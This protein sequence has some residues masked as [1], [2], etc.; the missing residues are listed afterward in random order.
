M[1]QLDQLLKDIT[2][3]QIKGN[4]ERRITGICFDS[5]KATPGSL[6]VAIK[7][8]ASD[9]HEYIN[10]AIEK[11]STVIVCQH[12]PSVCDPRVCYIVVDD[13]ARALGLL[14][15]S[16]YD[17]PSRQLSLTGVTGTNGKTTTATLLYRLFRA[18]GYSAGLFSTVANY[19]NDETYEATHTT[20]DPVQLNHLLHQMV[21][22]GCTHCFMEVSSHA[23]D[24][25]RVAGLSF[26]G[27]IFTNLTHDHLDYHKNFENYFKAKKSFFDMLGNEAFALS[28]ADDKKGKEILK[29]CRALCRT[30]G[31]KNDADF[32]ARLLES[33]FHGSLLQI[34][35]TEVWVHLIGEFN[36]YNLLAIYASALLLGVN[37]EE[38]LRYLSTLKEVKGR[39][40]RLQSSSG[41]IAIVDYAHTPDAVDNVLR[42]INRIRKGTEQVIT[43]LGAGGNRD[44]T[45]RP[46]MAKVAVENSDRVILTSD[47][48]RYENPEDILHDMEAGIPSSCQHKWATIV[49][50]REAIRAACL[51]ARPGDIILV[52]G[53][54]HETYQEIQG[55][56][57]HFDDYEV[58][59]EFLK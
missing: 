46:V 6:F 39:F 8:T 27:G 20:P 47:N 59:T 35:G 49:D 19:I 51:M 37:R 24:Q 4:P 30:Y 29:D 53:K 54:G 15:S 17:H 13:S 25:K 11:G 42:T 3:R 10:M 38:T 50:R 48:P 40:Q 12:L 36:A 58:L 5:R 7:G 26:K 14:S 34:D 1:K 21:K 16:F 55:V 56:K 52:A 23:L 32:K 57:H 41:I 45:K 28:N 43:V 2:P 9:G 33:H 22:A 18:M 44:K 31:L